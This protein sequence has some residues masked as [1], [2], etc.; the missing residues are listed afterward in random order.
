MQPLVSVC[1]ITYNHEKYIAQ[2]ID[3]FLM[4]RTNFPIE[5]VIGD[6]FSSDNTREIILGLQKKYPETISLIQRE[7]NI[8]VIPNLVDV[9]ANCKGKYIAFCEGD[10]YWIDPLKLQKQVNFLE[11]NLDF[12]LCF[13]DALVYWED[14]THRPFYFCRKLSKTTYQVEDVIKKWLMPSASMVFRKDAALPLPGWFVD[15]Y[16][17]DYAMQLL[18]AL[19]GKIYY[20]NEI[21]CVYRRNIVSLSANV[22]TSKISRNVIQL[23]DLYNKHTKY[24]YNDLIKARCDKYRRATY[25]CKIKRIFRPLYVKIYKIVYS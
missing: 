3:S 7:K 14:K 12:S 2:A 15:V 23:L 22:D 11:S 1:T 17:G 24:K 8:G 13:H 4:Q 10:D 19:K 21:M 16:N 6:D 9:L 18:L 25:K 5:I 20:F